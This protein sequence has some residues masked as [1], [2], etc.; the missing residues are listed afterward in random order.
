MHLKDIW[1]L[2]GVLLR[3]RVI[4]KRSRQAVTDG[5]KI[6]SRPLEH[7]RQKDRRLSAPVTLIR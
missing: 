6:R 3:R 5:V 1:Q 7:S 4:L 2:T